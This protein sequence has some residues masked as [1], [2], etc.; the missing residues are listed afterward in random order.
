MILGMTIVL[1]DV[2]GKRAFGEVDSVDKKTVMIDQAAPPVPSQCT[3]QAP[4]VPAASASKYDFS[5]MSHWNLTVSAWEELAKKD[6]DGVFAYARKCLETYEADAKTMAGSMRTFAGIGKEDDY[7]L[8]NDVAT[9]HYIMG[10]ADMKLNRIADAE[11]EFSYIIATYPYAQCWDPKGWFWKVADISRKNMEKM[12]NGN[13]GE[14][15]K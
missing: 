13:G 7:S 8:V 6:Y 1:Y 5:D 4:L 9:A 3:G 2:N 14:I 11:N 10:E 15:Q 12:K